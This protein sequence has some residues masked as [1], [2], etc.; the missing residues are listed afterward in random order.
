MSDTRQNK[1]PLEVIQEPCYNTGVQQKI[2]MV[3]IF[4]AFI[5]IW[6]FKWRL[7]RLFPPYP[8]IS[9]ERCLQRSRYRVL[10]PGPMERTCPEGRVLFTVL[11][12]HRPQT[13]RPQRKERNMK[14]YQPMTG[15]V[16]DALRS[17]VG[18]K[19]VWTDP[20]HLEQYKT[21]EE[22][23]PRKFHLPEA[24][25]AP[26]STE[27]ISAILKLA[28]REQ[29]PVT[30]RSGGTSVSDGAIPVCGGLVLL[31]ER[32]DKI[33]KVDPEGMYL[34]AQAGARTAAVQQAARDKGLFYAGDPCSADS[35]LIGG[36]L[37]TNAGGDKAVRYGTTRNQVHAMEVVLPN[38]QI[39][40]LGSRCK[41]NATG[42]CLDQLVIGSEGTLGIITEVTLKLL[43][44]APYKADVLAIFTDQA[45]ATGIVPVLLR[46]GLDPISVE[47][48]DNA[49][50]RSASD[51]SQ[52]DLGYY[53]DGSYVI[54]TLE[55]F[56]EED[57]D[58]KLIQLDE[59]C[60]SHGAA[61]V[62]VADERMWTLR[63]NC[64]E[65]ARVLSKVMTS[66]D[67]VV[68][69]DKIDQAIDVLSAE[70][71]KYPFQ[72]FT[73]AHAGDGNLHFA[74]LKGELSNQEWEEALDAFHEKAYQYIYA[75]GG[76]L[77]G[78]HGI[79]A[80]KVKQLA[81]LADPGELYM[82]E[83]IKRALDPLDILNPGKVLEVF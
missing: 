23:D 1:K 9:E 66:D 30:P 77:S 73:L 38:G 69:L 68:P 2:C 83:T 17:I 33:L 22:T 11:K 53:E 63:K 45:K 48:M 4:C 40:R 26:G 44:Q 57:L 35:C 12:L 18:E 37:A 71:R 76:K 39:A 16:L 74:I 7:Y 62:S 59:L 31:M 65:S 20:D 32:M 15:K 27:E 3:R 56:N 41:K 54:L 75:L 70:A 55:C 82:M 28:N 49:F 47:F 43:P 21:D 29:F 34:V 19:Y 58:R 10:S 61:D 81:Q 42:Y 52:L 13:R 6:F 80:K 64:L 60:R 8:P 51:Y 67:F 72:V 79:G 50:V 25:A 36:N 5:A 24:V 14:T 78:E 46:E